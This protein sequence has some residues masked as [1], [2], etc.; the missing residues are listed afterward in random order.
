MDYNQLKSKMKGDAVAE[1][2]DK[3]YEMT[4][5]GQRAGTGSDFKTAQANPFGQ[6]SS[7]PASVSAP[8]KQGE[9][10]SGRG[11]YEY[12]L[13]PDGA[14]VILKSGRGAAPG[15][16][17][18]EGM[19]GYKEI[20]QEFEDMKAGKPVS[21]KPRS[22]APKTSSRGVKV[23]DIGLTSTEDPD[24]KLL[25]QSA[26]RRQ[27]SRERLTRDFVQKGMPLAEAQEFAKRMRAPG[28]YDKGEPVMTDKR[29]ARK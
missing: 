14:F 15:T 7:A 6:V 2:E 8:A 9:R 13:L 10:F 5:K 24:T 22:V 16:I 27:D 18:K 26:M 12:G 20:K 25:R 28:G 11:G 1:Q 4:S 23:T 17:V 29:M 3:F 21:S 19:K